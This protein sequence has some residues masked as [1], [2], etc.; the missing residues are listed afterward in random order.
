MTTELQK[1]TQAPKDEAI[2]NGLSAVSSNVEA[3]LSTLEVVSRYKMSIE[4]EFEY[5]YLRCTF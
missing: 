2:E 1:T 5:S 3:I 4:A